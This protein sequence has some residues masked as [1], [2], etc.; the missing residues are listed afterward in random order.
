M[1]VIFC[2]W[3]VT[4]LHLDAPKAP[5]T[6]AQIL[7]AAIIDGGYTTNFMSESTN[8]Q[9][10]YRKYS[11]KIY[12]KY[13]ENIQKMYRKYSENSQKIYRKY[14]ENVENSLKKYKK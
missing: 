2:R 13:S 1:A 7:P 3:M 9:K 6:A 12:I 11:E 8:I 4:F 10:M 5:F 14:S